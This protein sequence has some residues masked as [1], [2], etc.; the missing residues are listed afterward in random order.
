VAELANDGTL[1][2]PRRV[3]RVQVMPGALESAARWAVV[4]PGEGDGVDAFVLDTDG[5]VLVGLSGYETVALPGA[6]TAAE[7]AP[8]EA[9][10]R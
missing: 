9:A 10:L 7:L 8:L 1:G 4:R 2:L 6:A 3:R 5:R